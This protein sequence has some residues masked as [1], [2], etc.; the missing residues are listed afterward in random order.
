MME[1]AQKLHYKSKKVELYIVVVEFFC[2]EIL[3]LPSLALTFYIFFSFIF[4]RM[5]NCQLQIGLSMLFE[6][7]L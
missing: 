7:I 4:V 3:V 5:T 2:R 6:H 1:R